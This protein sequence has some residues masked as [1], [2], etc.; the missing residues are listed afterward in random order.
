MKVTRIILGFFAF[1]VLIFAAYAVLRTVPIDNCGENGAGPACIKLPPDFS[2]DYYAE[3]VGGARSMTLSPGGTLFVGSRDTGKVYAVPDRNRDNKADEVIVLA[4]DLDMPNGV[5]FRNGSLYV[6]E[7]SRVIRYDNIEA[8]LENPPEPVVVNGDFPSDR[9][10]G[11]KYIKFGPDGKLYVPVGMPC[12]VCEKEEELYGTIMRMEHDG[13]Q[14][15]IF[16]RGIRNTVGFAWNPETEELWFTDNGRDWLGDNLPPDELNRAPEPGMNFGFPYC[17]AGDIPDP[18]YGGLRNC[19][20]F[21]PPEIKLD[22]HV[23]SLGMTFY[24][25]TMFPEEYRNQI[26]IAEH[27]SW[28]RKIPIGYRVTLVRLENG[29]PVSYEPFAEGWLLGLAAWGRPVDVLV[30][31]DGALLVSDDKNNAIYRISYG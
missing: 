28:N 1:V 24:T 23:A 12:N 25:G 2:I 3:N 27:G 9:A 7:V 4:K 30:M 31:P 11:W 16:A 5:A 6:A 13:S 29:T 17:H 20:E 8:R 19:S 21:T 18:E 14:L 15:E 26:F 22:P 10:H